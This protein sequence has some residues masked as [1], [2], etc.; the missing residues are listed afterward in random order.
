M[1]F[2]VSTHLYH[3]QRLSREHLREIARARV[4][5]GRAVRD[6]DAIST[7]TTRRRSPSCSSGWPRPGSSCTACTRRSRESFAGGRWGAPSRPGERRRRT[8]ARGGAE[9]ERGA[10]HRA[11]D[12]VRRAGRAPRHCRGRSRPGREQPRRRRAAASR[13]LQRLAEPLGVRVARRS[14]PERAVATPA[15]LV[16]FVEE[17]LDAPRTSASASTSATRTWTATSSTRSRRC[18]SI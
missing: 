13:R 9:A 2:G 7:T 14:D 5:G 17:D 11:A 15:S 10:A 16:H 8:R 4:R 3:N 6:P 18:R 1:R 12:S